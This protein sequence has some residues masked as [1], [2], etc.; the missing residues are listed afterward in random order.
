MNCVSPPELDDR[1]LLAYSD[2]EADR[3]VVTHLE[4]CAYCLERANELARL[5]KRLTARLYRLTCPSPMDLGEYHLGLLPATQA[6]AVMQHLREC[7]HCQREVAQLE[8][9]LGELAPIPEASLLKRAKVLIARLV[10]GKADS[11]SP[12]EPAF[13]PALAAL[14]GEAQGLITLEANG[15]SIVLDVQSAAEGRVNILGQIAADDQDR[16][17]NASVDLRQAGALHMTSTVDDL[18]AFRFESILP[19]STEFLITP[20]SG[21]AVLVPAIDIATT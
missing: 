4:R 19:G 3:E 6:V 15:L 9:F 12:G 1:Q 16:W 10:G 2:G 5:Q 21:E 18:G 14:R 11:G 13:V 20:S 8:N 17:T 7:P